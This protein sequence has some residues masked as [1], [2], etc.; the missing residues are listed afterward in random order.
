[1]VRLRRE[2]SRID[3]EP[4]S[5]RVPDSGG[6]NTGPGTMMVEE[7]GRKPSRQ[8]FFLQTDVLL[9]LVAIKYGT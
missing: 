2:H 4:Y 6:P 8:T 7:A 5:A 1:M 3:G 9:D